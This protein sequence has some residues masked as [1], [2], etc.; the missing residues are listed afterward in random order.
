M[1][2][3][4][5]NHNNY[6]SPEIPPQTGIEWQGALGLTHALRAPTVR[7]ALGYDKLTFDRLA[8]T[9]CRDGVPMDHEALQQV[10]VRFAVYR[11]RA[12]DPH[13]RETP[14]ET[15]QAVSFVARE[16]PFHPV[17][18]WLSSLQW[19]GQPRFAKL[20]E[21]TLMVDKGSVPLAT[22]LLRRWFVQAVAHAF[23]PGC[24]THGLLVLVNESK[25]VADLTIRQL[26]PPRF[27]LDN[28][29]RPGTPEFSRQLR[30][31]W[32]CGL[33]EL[34]GLSGGYGNPFVEWL[35][36]THDDVQGLF[37]MTDERAPRTTVFATGTDELP[38]VHDGVT[39]RRLWVIPTADVDRQELVADRDQLWAEAVTAYLAGESWDMTP[40]EEED[41]F[42]TFEES[43]APDPWEEQIMQYIS[44]RDA[45]R[46]LTMRDIVIDGLGLPLEEVRR[47]A[48]RIGAVL[49][50][51]GFVKARRRKSGA[52][53]C[54]WVP[55]EE[56]PEDE[57]PESPVVETQPESTTSVAGA[58]AHHER[59]M[60]VHERPERP[61][62]K[63]QPESRGCAIGVD[64]HG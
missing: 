34:E 51:A 9:A 28:P 36:A 63:S 53:L 40:T 19:D 16:A 38:Q 1:K 25:L 31:A 26:V 2:A 33:P 56:H 13:W 27:Y 61:T 55:G 30:R 41:L 58:D 48:H 4:I 37:T 14:L 32:V 29:A 44:E 20:S 8:W 50:R 43:P 47:S 42:C 6:A 12:G 24:P 10:R 22:S 3:A 62:S 18:D 45:T 60:N 21:E 5:Q 15:A 17:A 57:R 54:I 64:A 11:A 23:E 52:K 59:P 49:W 35:S 46:P 39:Q 7:E